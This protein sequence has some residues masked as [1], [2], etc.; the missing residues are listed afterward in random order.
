MKIPM[1][2]D[3]LKS[4]TLSRWFTRVDACSSDACMA[5]FGKVLVPI[6]PLPPGMLSKLPPAD[7]EFAFR[8]YNDYKVPPFL[9]M[10]GEGLC[11]EILPY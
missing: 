1:Q 10:A 7:W 9:I 2:T 4:L 3:K 6:N 8:Y 5:S 11:R